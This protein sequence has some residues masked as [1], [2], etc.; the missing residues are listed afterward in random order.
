MK[1]GYLIEERNSALLLLDMKSKTFTSQY[2]D[3]ATRRQPGEAENTLDLF[4]TNDAELFQEVSTENTIMSDHDLVKIDLGYNF[5]NLQPPTPEEI[6]PEYKLIKDQSLSQFNFTNANFEKI[7]EQLND[8]DWDNLK[9]SNSEEGFV[10]AFYNILFEICKK[11]VPLKKTKLPNNQSKTSSGNLNKPTLR[12]LRNHSRKRRKMQKHLEFLYTFQPHSPTIHVLLNKMKAL[13]VKSKDAIIKDKKSQESK[14]VET[15]KSN[16]RYFYSYAKRFSKRKSKVGPLKLKKGNTTTLIKDSRRIAN[17]LQDQFKSVFSDPDSINVADYDCGDAGSNPE[18]PKIQSFHFSIED[19]LK[20]IT[21]IKS[22]SSSG[23]DGISATLLKNCKGS[24]SY[25]IY[26]IWKMSFDSGFIHKTFLTQMITPI[27]K[28]GSKSKPE[29]YR[30]ISLTSHIIKIFE[31]IVRDKLVHFLESN[32][33]LN[34]FQHGFRHGRSCLSELLAHFDDMLVNLNQG[35]DI[36]VIYLDFAKAF[37]KVDH[38]ILLKKIRCMGISGKLYDWIK[39]FLNNRYQKVVVDGF[40]SYITLVLSGVPQGTVLGPILFL[41]YLNDINSSIK[42]GCT[43][44]SFADDSRL[45]K[46]ISTYQDALSLQLDLQNVISWT[47]ANNMALHQDKFEVLQYSTSLNNITKSLFELLPFNEYAR[48]YN[49]SDGLV[50]KATDHVQD[51]GIGM[52]SQLDFSSHINLIVDKACSKAAWALSVFQCRNIN[53]MMTLYKSLVR[54]LLEYCCPLWNPSKILDIQ[55]IENVQRNFTSKISGFEN[56]SYWDRLKQLNLMSLQRRRERFCI[57]YMWKILNCHVPNDISINWHMNVRL[58]FKAVVPSMSLN[59]KV[60]PI[61]ESSFCVNGARLW[62]TL[63]KSI[64][65]DQDF[66]SFKRK[67]DNFLLSLPDEPP[68]KGYSSRNNNSLLQWS[69]FRF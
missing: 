35:N 69:N 48:N 57:I 5:L 30:P 13:E 8:I 51:L 24:L 47:A 9:E 29:N 15:M 36:D 62:N 28:K 68:V 55:C 19:I 23:E 16:P 61:H 65:C 7:D 63:P 34:S 22:S 53:T 32:N 42:C 21:E 6:K 54:P 37:D 46:S 1:S 10:D 56:L 18:S 44:R 11:T 52:S 20:A 49:T 50:L 43:L 58:G 66:N 12:V 64:N 4:F 31:R 25:P 39:S 41:I 2:V 27:H 38:N 67:L 14:A 60:S 40:H 17:A 45:F 26:L 59:R 3:I 33:L